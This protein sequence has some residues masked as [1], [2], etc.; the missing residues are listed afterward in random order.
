M[1]TTPAVRQ[2]AT[3]A[4]R[5]LAQDIATQLSDDDFR[6]QLAASLP[7]GITVEK[8]ASVTLTALMDD[9]VRQSDESKRLIACDRLSL[10]QAVIKCAQDGLLPDGRE[11]AL[12][13]RGKTAV[14][15]PMVGGF[16]KIAGQHGW[17]I[18]SEAVYANDEFDFTTEPPTI[19]HRPV[20]PGEERG[21]IVAAYAVARHRDGRREQVVMPQEDIAKRRAQATTDQVWA[22]WPAEM[23]EKTVVRDLFAELPLDPADKRVARLIATELIPGEAATMLYGTTPIE[24]SPE[25]Q[26]PTTSVDPGDE[27]QQ[28]GADEA[29][30]SSETDGSSASAP[31]DN[32]FG[33]AEEEDGG[34]MA[35]AQDAAA[36][37]VALD[38]TAKLKWPNGLTLA[39]INA[40]GDEGQSFFRWALGP[41]SPDAIRTAAAAYAKVQLPFLHEELV[42]GQA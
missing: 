16:R 9:A 14:Y 42:G 22:K 18:R 27:S 38:P 20:R 25:E 7:E 30:S 35:A 2:D 24:A 40:R 8:F 32:D 36:F 11:A 37:V 29:A 34:D 10:F 41:N 33:G 6:A 26:S 5:T 19:A 4:A 1:S 13:K 21:Q 28:V 12:V 3:P 23:S 39:Q 31:G 15:Q 17:T